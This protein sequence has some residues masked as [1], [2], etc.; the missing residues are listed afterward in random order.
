MAGQ[1]HLSLSHSFPE[2]DSRSIQSPTIGHV[3]DYVR[4]VHWPTEQVKEQEGE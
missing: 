4:Q 1:N 3:S 2:T